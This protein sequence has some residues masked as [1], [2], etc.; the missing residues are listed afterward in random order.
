MRAGAGG[1]IRLGRVTGA[2]VKLLQWF[3]AW[4]DFFREPLD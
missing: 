4:H 3:A 2:K 1:S